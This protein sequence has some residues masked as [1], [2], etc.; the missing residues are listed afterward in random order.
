MYNKLY[1]MDDWL[2]MLKILPNHRLLWTADR[3]PRPQIRIVIAPSK[4]RRI[5][6]GVSPCREEVS[7][8]FL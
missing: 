1:N 3:P 8:G 6:H 7:N 4:A 2:S 5:L